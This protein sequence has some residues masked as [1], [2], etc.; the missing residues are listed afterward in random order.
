MADEQMLQKKKFNAAFGMILRDLYFENEDVKK[1]RSKWLILHYSEIRGLCLPYFPK[2]SSF[3]SFS[4][5][6]TLFFP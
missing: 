1:K 4:F 2:V 6:T 3:F 5:R